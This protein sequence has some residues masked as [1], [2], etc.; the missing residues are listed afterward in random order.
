MRISKPVVALVA[1]ACAAGLA[2]CGSQGPS[3]AAASGGPNPAAHANFL[4][5]SQCMRSHGL[6]NFPDPSPSGGIH[7][8]A[9]SGLDPQSPQFQSAQ[10]A[11]KKL[12][13]GGGPPSHP[14]AQDKA[15]MLHISQCMRRHGV[16][17]FPDPT[18]GPP[19]NP[20]GYS[21]VIDRGGVVLA[22]P[23]TID[24]ASPAF[25]Q[26]ASACKFGF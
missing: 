19:P 7:L 22:V 23:K 16:T 17:G 9:S 14:T 4:K 8:D 18:T 3:S 6:S 5:F 20:T 13:P 24:A 2:A 12:L 26:A 21:Q 10:Q 1:I 25:K 11:C 15:Q